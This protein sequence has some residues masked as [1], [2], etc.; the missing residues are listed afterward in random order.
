MLLKVVCVYVCV[1]VG[2]MFFSFL[3]Q[4]NNEIETT[5]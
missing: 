2:Q 4:Q 3:L 5:A 1:C